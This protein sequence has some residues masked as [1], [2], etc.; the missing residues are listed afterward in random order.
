ML[1]PDS[2]D[3]VE[4]VLMGLDAAEKAFGVDVNGKGFKVTRGVGV[5]QVRSSSV[6]SLSTV[7]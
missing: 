1:R 6:V 3:P 7:C 4:A 5:I 2:G